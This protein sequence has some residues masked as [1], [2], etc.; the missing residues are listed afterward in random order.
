MRNSK[1]TK[2]KH[3]VIEDAKALEQRLDIDYNRVPKKNIDLF[4][5]QMEVI[6]DILD[7]S[8]N[9]KRYILVG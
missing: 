2:I 5:K 4:P 3:Q 8:E 7:N 6:K 9:C 1:R